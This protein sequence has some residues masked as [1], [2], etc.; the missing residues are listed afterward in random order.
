[1]A[2]WQLVN[3]QTSHIQR[4]ATLYAESHWLLLRVVEHC[5][6]YGSHRRLAA[7]GAS[8]VA[9]PCLMTSLLAEPSTFRFAPQRKPGPRPPG[10]FCAAR[11]W[12]G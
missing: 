6:S 10:R 4:M 2:W 5:L 11:W 9:L 1:M 12:Q 3:L 8:L 7:T